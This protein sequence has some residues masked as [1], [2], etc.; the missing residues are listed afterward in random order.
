M[1]CKLCRQ[2][3]KLIDA[4]IIPRSF[5]DQLDDDSGPI[6]IGTGKPGV[7]P[8]RSPMGAYDS[9]LVCE[10]CEALFS[11][12]DDYA[13]RLLL[14]PY[15]EAAY[16]VINGEKIA[17]RFDS[18]DYQKL[19]MFFIS[20]L[21]RASASKHYFF[22]GVK[23]GPFQDLAGQMIVSNDPGDPQTFS[24]VLSRFEHP[25][26]VVML[27]P[28]LTKFGDV[29]FYRFY[30]AGYVALVKVDKRKLPEAFEGLELAPDRSLIVLLRDFRSSKELP[31]LKKLA[32]AITRRKTKQ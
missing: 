23:L 18:V 17:Y 32:S 1:I 12:W 20:L 28:D 22:D 27:N 26:A 31:V 13:N 8:K 19:K 24:V 7:Y 9:R 5:F 2:N 3:R 21:W 10:S 15:L 11:P 6:R 25:T 14:A 4:H 30:L 29:N 16:L